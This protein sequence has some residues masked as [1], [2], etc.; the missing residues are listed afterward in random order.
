MVVSGVRLIGDCKLAVGVNLSVNAYLF[1]C[2]S[3]QPGNLSRV[4]PAFH[5]VAAGLDS[6]LHH[7]HNPEL[8]KRRKIDVWQWTGPYS[9]PASLVSLTMINV[10]RSI[11]LMIWLMT[12][13]HT[14]TARCRRQSS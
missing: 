4:Y 12:I 14:G 10:Q 2:V 5:T 3:R 8:D 6:S 1:L 7:P 13:H 9:K 11:I